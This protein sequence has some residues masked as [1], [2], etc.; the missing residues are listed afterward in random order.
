V[1]SE[2]LWGTH[3]PEYLELKRNMLKE[4]VALW[5]EEF[6]A[7]GTGRYRFPYEH[8]WKGFGSS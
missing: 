4:C 5:N 7:P 6:V 1:E 3:M 2:A 8:Y